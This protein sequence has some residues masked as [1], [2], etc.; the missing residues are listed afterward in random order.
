M[1]Y[2]V[3]PT[4]AYLAMRGCSVAAL[5]ILAACARQPQIERETLLAARI[6]V[7]GVDEN[8]RFGACAAL[9][10]DIDRDGYSE[11]AVGS[12]GTGPGGGGS[13][14]VLSGATGAIMRR[15][16]MA[17]VAGSWAEF[18]HTMIVVD[19]VDHD[20]YSDLV[21]SHSPRDPVN[22]FG[23]SSVITYSSLTGSELA[24]FI[25][26]AY[27]CFGYSLSIMP[28]ST[29]QSALVVGAPRN[30]MAY[31]D[32]RLSTSGSRLAHIEANAIGKP[33]GP[34]GLGTAVSVIGDV[35]GDGRCDIAAV[36]PGCDS[37]N[38]RLYAISTLAQT[39]KW[40]APLP[41]GFDY[42]RLLRTRDYNQDGV[43]DIVLVRPS[44]NGVSSG[45]RGSLVV[46]SGATGAHL[47]ELSNPANVVI[48][49]AVGSGM[50]VF[51]LT[52]SDSVEEDVV[53][54]KLLHSP[55]RLAEV[56]R[57]PSAG[58]EW[59]LLPC[60]EVDD[61]GALVRVL[62]AAPDHGSGVIAVLDDN[63]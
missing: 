37:Y 55:L 57:V 35:D 63:R 16:D 17:P 10:P 12:P 61:S 39:V 36:D 2:F 7:H 6:T 62:L 5:G 56:L 19:D 31:V 43:A 25:G 38:G 34:L 14:V 9:L 1:K 29:Q 13:V 53:I 26:D 44:T 11:V 20:D 21:V 49:D 60:A 23:A 58:V 42:A 52:V 46:F 51:L 48:V 4:Q 22:G 27:D 54:S 41:S 28:L 47:G 59:S 18:G 3:P 8:Q 24:S 15:H 32:L 45:D 40:S 30:P 33:M 50:C